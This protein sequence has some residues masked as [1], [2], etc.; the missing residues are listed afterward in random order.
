MSAEAALSPEAQM[1]A[2][3]VKMVLTAELRT[4]ENLNDY[5]GRRRGT[6]S[7][8]FDPDGDRTCGGAGGL[9]S[10]YRVTV[11]VGGCV[12]TIQDTIEG[13]IAGNRESNDDARDGVSL[14]IEHRRLKAG[15]GP[16]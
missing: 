14:V 13:D 7:E 8:H 11:V 4:G 10:V 5:V 16:A 1:N 3:T 6:R 12:S 9:D 15:D 2:A